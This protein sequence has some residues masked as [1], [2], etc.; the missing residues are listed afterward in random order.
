MY[1]TQLAIVFNDMKCICQRPLLCSTCH[2]WKRVS[3]LL[4]MPEL[5]PI[6]LSPGLALDLPNYPT[7]IQYRPNVY[8]WL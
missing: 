5:A 2:G 4:G 8:T 3:L 1:F 7:A 6:R